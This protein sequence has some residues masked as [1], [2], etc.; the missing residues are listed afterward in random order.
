[1]T[2]FALRSNEKE[3]M[4]DFSPDDPSVSV[5]LRELA[6]IN[7][8]LGG[9]LPSLRGI[10]ELLRESCTS[11]TGSPNGDKA[12]TVLDIGTGDGDMPREIV[13]WASRVGKKARIKGIDRVADT[14]RVARDACRGYETI[15]IA[16]ENFFS[17]KDDAEYDIVH[18]S[19]LLHHFERDELICAIRKMRASSRYGVIINDLHR[20]WFAYYAIRIL[21]RLFFHSRTIRHDAPVSVLRSFTRTELEE[22]LH[23]AGVERYKISWYWAF[24]WQ[25]VIWK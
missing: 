24:R 6:F 12:F 22:L 5:T 18:A 19:L 10:A 17:S 13:K 2:N 8:M 25:I 14:V 4:D 16:E 1:M 11:G 20:H 23:Q 3:W 7:E 21:T 9:Y 15:E